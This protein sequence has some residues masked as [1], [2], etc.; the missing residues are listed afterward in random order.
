MSMELSV[1]TTLYQSSP[2]LR[3]FYQRASRAAAAV[4]RDF[5]IVLV[6]DGSPDDSLEIALDLHRTDPRVV[7]V[8]LSRNFGHHEAAL[9]GLEHAR[10]ER[11]FLIDSDL[12]EPPEILVDFHTRLRQA[13]CDVVYGVQDRRKGGWFEQYS[14][15]MFYRVF[16]AFSSVEL[17]RNAVMARLMTRR[18]VNA[19]LQYQERELFMAGLW[20]LAGFG[21]EPVPVNK[22]HKGVTS[23]TLRRKLS[24]L[25]KAVT[26]FS[27]KPLRVIFHVGALLSLLSAAYIVY[28]VGRKALFDIGVDGWTSLVVSVWFLGGLTILFLG[29]IGI[30]LSKVF[31]EIKQRPRSITRSVYRREA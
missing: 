23:Y 9:S 28:L 19:L 13:G 30:Y 2:T 7:V 6:N 25:L 20:A 21:Q 3:E 31:V 14:G 5:E 1:V 24:L 26:S 18:Y 29:V 15:D 12:E 16:N 11:V 4:A 17:P 8:D 27:D 10:G 22:S